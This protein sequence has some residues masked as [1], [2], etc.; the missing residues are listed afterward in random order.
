GHTMPPSPPRLKSGP[1]LFRP[2]ALAR[3]RFKREALLGSILVLGII[4][5]FLWRLKNHSNQLIPSATVTKIAVLPL[6]N[7][8]PDHNLD[9]LCFTFSDEIAKVLASS[10]K[11]DVS[12]S[13]RELAVYDTVMTRRY[14]TSDL[15][16]QQIGRELHVTNILSGNF[17][18]QDEHLLFTLEDVD[19]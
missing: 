9:Y 16:P 5:A 1:E 11:M 15:D 14:A 10:R 8:T 2:G 6:Q 12:P 3:S 7:L 13:A 19:V 18:R 4:S 17:V